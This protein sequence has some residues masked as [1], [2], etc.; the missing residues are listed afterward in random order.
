MDD[1]AMLRS[2]TSYASQESDQCFTPTSANPYNNPY[3]GQ[4]NPYGDVAAVGRH[5]VMKQQKEKESDF[6]ILLTAFVGVI[7]VILLFYFTFRAGKVPKP[8]RNRVTVAPVTAGTVALNKALDNM[9]WETAKHTKKE[10]VKHEEMIGPNGEDLTNDFKGLKKKAKM[11]FKLDSNKDAFLAGADVP[12]ET[13]ELLDTNNDQAVSYDEFTHGF[14]HVDT[15]TKLKAFKKYYGE[16]YGSVLPSHWSHKILHKEGAKDDDRHLE[17]ALDT[18]AAIPD[19]FAAADKNN[20][21]RLNAAE[22]D[23]AG[24]RD[25]EGS[26]KADAN[27]DGFVTMD[28]FKKFVT[29]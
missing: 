2:R 11:F 23:S 6:W 14:D 29:A 7:F 21:E 16:V 17:H 4:S 19:R 9:K 20:D 15:D 25:E 5:G 3:A 10:N 22:A 27:K 12:K 13:L 28:E 1:S 18:E 26:V 8:L 24:L